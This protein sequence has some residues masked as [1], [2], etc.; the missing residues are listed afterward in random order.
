[1]TSAATIAG[2]Y[3]AGGRS[4]WLIFSRERST[5]LL[6]S[7]ILIPKCLLVFGFVKGRFTGTRPMRSALQTALCRRRRSCLCNSTR[8]EADFRLT[9]IIAAGKFQTQSG[10][11]QGLLNT[12]WCAPTSRRRAPLI[13]RVHSNK[14][15]DGAS[16]RSLS[17]SF[18]GTTKGC[19]SDSL[20]GVL[21]VIMMLPVGARTSR[22][23]TLNSMNRELRGALGL[24]CRV[25]EWTA[26]HPPNCDE[27]VS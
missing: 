22:A 10:K 8:I 2:A 12:Q 17:D 6:L 4:R 1:M 27:L 7:I 19:K 23:P 18:N 5:A 3:I 16:D 15:H 26:C 20:S 21:K 11:G 14:A 25:P 13:L 9:S 24:S